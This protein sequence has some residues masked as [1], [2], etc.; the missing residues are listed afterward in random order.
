[1]TTATCETRQT[2]RKMVYLFLFSSGILAS[3][4]ILTRIFSVVFW[5]HFAFLVL[6]TAMLGFGIG[7]FLVRSH[8]AALKRY[9]RTMVLGVGSLSGGAA[10]LIA[11][12]VITHNPF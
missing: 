11:L 3:E 2:L 5:Y 12:F 7:G 6:S 4:I 8:A 1:M 9:S 10:L